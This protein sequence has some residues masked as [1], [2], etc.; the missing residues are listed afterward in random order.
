[1]RVGGYARDTTNGEVERFEFK[2]RLA[3]KRH[4]ETAETAVD[5][6]WNVVMHSELDRLHYRLHSMINKRADETDTRKESY[7]DINQRVYG[8][9]RRQKDEY[10]G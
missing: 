9:I 3:H 2:S 10:R 7:V 1:M 5:V 6:D 4:E 8:L